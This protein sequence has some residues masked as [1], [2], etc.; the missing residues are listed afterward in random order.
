LAK[1]VEDVRPP[2]AEVGDLRRQPPR[3]QTEAQD[4]DW[5]LEQFRGNPSQERPGEVVWRDER[6]VPVDGVGG[7]GFAAVQDE[8]DRPARRAQGGII[9]VAL[10]IDGSEAGRE[11]HRIALA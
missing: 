10:G 9:E 4:V 2:L 11:Q 1:A 7:V 5:R 6:P 8:V 3:V